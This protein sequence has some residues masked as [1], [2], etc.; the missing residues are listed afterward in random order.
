[1]LTAHAHRHFTV[2]RICEDTSRVFTVACRS[3]SVNIPRLAMA[4]RRSLRA[5]PPAYLCYTDRHFSYAIPPT[6]ADFSVDAYFLCSS[7]LP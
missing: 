5:G 6:S 2:Y 3:P 4:S 7:S 1:M